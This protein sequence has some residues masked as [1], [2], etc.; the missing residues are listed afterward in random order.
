MRL[1]L[2]QKINYA[3][4]IADDYQRMYYFYL[5]YLIDNPKFYYLNLNSDKCSHSEFRKCLKKLRENYLRKLDIKFCGLIEHQ[6]DHKNYHSHLVVC[7]AEEELRNLKKHESEITAHW[8]KAGGTSKKLFEPYEKGEANGP[9]GMAFYMCK[10]SKNRVR[11]KTIGGFTSNIL[12]CNLGELPWKG[13]A[14]PSQK[15]HRPKLIGLSEDL[16]RIYRADP[17]NG[18]QAKMLCFF[19]A[20][21]EMERIKFGI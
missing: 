10:S 9:L 8:I 17:K 3:R 7:G 16:F 5:S 15:I 4:C 2:N 11:T 21:K 20:V 12:H 19:E 18:E 6:G 14:L 13:K 1:T